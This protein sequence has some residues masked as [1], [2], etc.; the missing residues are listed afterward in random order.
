MRDFLYTLPVG[1]IFHSPER[2]Y[3]VESVLGQ[4][5]FCIIYK[6]SS[7]GLLQLLNIPIENCVL[8]LSIG[9]KNY[10]FCGNHDVAEEAAI[11]YT[12]KGCCKL[13]GV[14]FRK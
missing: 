5:G 12:M 9:R 3:I 7:I 13:A 6:V 2:D 10:M 14:D 4:G 1:S 11:M 8:P